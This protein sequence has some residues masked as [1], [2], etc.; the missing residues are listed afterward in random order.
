MQIYDF[1]SSPNSRKVRALVYE[2]DLHPTFVSLN[3]FKGEHKKS[4]EL[5]AKNPNSK[6]PVLED[7]D[8]SLWE[9]NAIL[10]YLAAQR[11]ERGLSPI[12]PKRRADVERWLFWQTAHLAPPVTRVGT[13]RFVKKLT[14]RGEPDQ[15]IVDAGAA[16]FATA[17]KVLDVALAG[18]EYVAGEL[19]VADFALWGYYALARLSDLDVAPYPQ[20]SAWLTRIESRNSVKAAIVDANKIIEQVRAG[21]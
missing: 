1:A 18:R 12:E 13:E 6:L 21:A 8:F 14:K 16:E 15:A 7:G 9:S 2:L 20:L 17:C 10:N 5:L 19:S 11:P 4:Q 3:V